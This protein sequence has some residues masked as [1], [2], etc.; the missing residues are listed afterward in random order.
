VLETALHDVTSTRKEIAERL[1]TIERTL[2]HKIRTYD[3]GSAR[4]S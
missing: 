2:Y 1:H 3:L 4:R